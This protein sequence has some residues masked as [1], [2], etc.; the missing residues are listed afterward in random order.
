[1][2]NREIRPADLTFFDAAGR[3]V[4]SVRDFLLL[5][6]SEEAEAQLVSRKDESTKRQLHFGSTHKNSSRASGCENE[7]TNIL[8]TDS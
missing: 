7:T 5:F 3:L 6:E 2:K 1:M 8:T 4:F